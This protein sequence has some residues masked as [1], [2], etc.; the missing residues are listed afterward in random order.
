MIGHTNRQTEITT[1]YRYAGILIICHICKHITRFIF[2]LFNFI[3]RGVYRNLEK[4]GG[5]NF[6]HFALF[7]IVIYDNNIGLFIAYYRSP[8]PSN[9]KTIIFFGKEI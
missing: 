9:Y 1:L 8:I 5:I 6:Y 7:Y 4:G 3:L 2:T